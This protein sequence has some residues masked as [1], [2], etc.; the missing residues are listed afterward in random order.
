MRNNVKNKICDLKEV[1][2]LIK[3]DRQLTFLDVCFKRGI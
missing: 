2:T 3:K 1:A